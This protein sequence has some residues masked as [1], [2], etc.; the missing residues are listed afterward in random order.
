MNT[1][2]LSYWVKNAKTF[3][4]GAQI[5]FAAN[6]WTKVVKEF[7]AKNNLL[8]IEHAKNTRWPEN[9]LVQQIQLINKGEKE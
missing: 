1:Y 2:T 4:P 3:E 5:F 7:Y 8:A 6:G 9:S